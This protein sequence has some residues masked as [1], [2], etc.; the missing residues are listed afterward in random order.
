M[1][2]VWNG[3][4]LIVRRSKAFGNTNAIAERRGGVERIFAGGP[5]EASSL[6]SIIEPPRRNRLRPMQ[7]G[8]Q[9]GAGSLKFEM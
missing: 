2:I 9:V 7:N 6:S 5:L 4:G 3:R 1:A 8:F